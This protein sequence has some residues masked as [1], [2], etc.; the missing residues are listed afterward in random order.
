MSPR[1]ARHGLGNTFFGGLLLS[2][3][4]AGPRPILLSS[5]ISSPSSASV[6]ADPTR[7]TI[8]RRPFIWSTTYTAVAPDAVRTRRIPATHPP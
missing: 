2:Q 3:D 4:D 6:C 5:C 7:A 1:R 8:R